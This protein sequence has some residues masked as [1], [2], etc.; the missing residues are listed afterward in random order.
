MTTKLLLINPF[1]PRSDHIQPPLGLG[2]LAAAARKNGIE[3]SL[4]DANRFKTD[5]SKLGKLIKKEK[6]DFVGFQFYTMNFDQV[7]RGLETTKKINQK[8][9]TLVGGPHPSALPEETLSDLGENLDFA[10]C[11]EAEVGLPQLLKTVAEGKNEFSNIPGLIYR[12]GG[13]TIINEPNF[14]KDLD[15]LDPPAWDLLKPRV[16]PEAQHGAFFE[17]FPIAPI[18]TTRGCPFNCTFCAGK[19]NTGSLLRKRSVN[20]VIEEIRYLYT[21]HHIKEFHIVDDNFTL[22]KEYAKKILKEIINLDLKISFAV[23]N[24]I[25]LDTLDEEIL[26]LMKNA[27]FYLISVGIESGSD[28]ILKLMGKHLSIKQIKEKVS[29]IKSVGLDAA[30]FFILGYPGETEKEIKKTINFSLNLGLLRANYFIFLPLPG[31]AI[32]KQ[33]QKEG[34]LKKIEYD[35]LSF[36]SPV[37]SDSLNKK[38][39]KNLQR[40]AFL[41][42]YFL[43]PKI[44]LKNLQKIK[45]KEQIK[46]LL[47]RTFHWLF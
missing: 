22:D 5:S 23:P 40:Q 44:L 25:R 34:K 10:F 8:I 17:N 24:G 4:Y 7:K 14:P 16:Y 29:L 42:F 19:L 37:F 2:Y 13:E 28:R 21:N 38:K 33:L 26:V 11:G 35:E 3:V 6:P 27:G 36:T 32:Y 1:N 45:K 39:L 20:H 46:F 18:I 41:R 31:T 43:R 15:E 9:I 47:R 12:N 30:G